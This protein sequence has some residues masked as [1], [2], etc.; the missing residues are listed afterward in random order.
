MDEKIGLEKAPQVN[1]SR[2]KLEASEAIR[3]QV[4]RIGAELQ[5]EEEKEAE[6]L[7]E[8]KGGQVMS[9]TKS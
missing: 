1:S 3:Q 2:P 7:F 9:P 5:R 8:G 6:E 4:L